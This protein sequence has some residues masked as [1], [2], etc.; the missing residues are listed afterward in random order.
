MVPPAIAIPIKPIAYATGPVSEAAMA[1]IGASQGRPPPAGAADE[2]I[3][4]VRAIAVNIKAREKRT[5]ACEMV[6]EFI[7]CFSFFGCC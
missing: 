2:N 1:V 5:R 4:N 7:V 3:A 6:L